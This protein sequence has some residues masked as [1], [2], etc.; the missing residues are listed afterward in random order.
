MLCGHSLE[1]PQGDA[2]NEYPQHM[3]CA[4]I[5]KNI[6]SFWVKKKSK[7]SGAM[8]FRPK[9]KKKKTVFPETLLTLIFWPYI[10]FLR[11]GKKFI[12]FMH[13]FIHFQKS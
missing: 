6:L 10:N 4:E 11:G 2:S 1:V 12:I 8:M 5:R 9:Y 13:T 3:F 7:L